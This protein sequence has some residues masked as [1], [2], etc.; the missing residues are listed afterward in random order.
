MYDFQ[1]RIMTN[2][3]F[4]F[5]YNCVCECV[6]TNSP[7]HISILSL[8]AFFVYSLRRMTSLSQSIYI[9]YIDALTFECILENKMH[10]TFRYILVH[11]S[12]S[13]P[14]HVPSRILSVSI[15]CKSLKW[16]Q[17][18]LIKYL[19]ITHENWKF[20]VQSKNTITI[21]N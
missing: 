20:T 8:W 16:T 6:R 15:L 5:V 11:S 7:T 9:Y 1:K 14:V 2:V 10:F 12:M 3:F 4:I 18:L 21:F 13:F 19:Y 17:F